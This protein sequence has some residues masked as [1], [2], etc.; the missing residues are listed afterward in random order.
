[1]SGG[2]HGH[3]DDILALAMPETP[4]DFAAT[5]IGIDTLTI[6]EIT[7][8]LVDV[9][10]MIRAAFRESTA[11]PEVTRTVPQT[12]FSLSNLTEELHRELPNLFSIKITSPAENIGQALEVARLNSL[13]ITEPV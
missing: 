6:A 13:A 9:E 3:N 11:Y 1:M 4:I 12:I 2:F 5:I 8:L 7:Q 10:N